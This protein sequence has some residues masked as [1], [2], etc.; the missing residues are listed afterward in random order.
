MAE[1]EL[2]N[3]NTTPA[4][5]EVKIE[6]SVASSPDGS[7]SDGSS[8][9]SSS[10]D[11]SSSDGSSSAGRSS[12]FKPL[13]KSSNSK[14]QENNNSVG[15]QKNRKRLEKNGQKRI[16]TA[17]IDTV[18][19]TSKKPR[20]NTVEDCNIKVE[21]I[22][23]DETDTNKE[24]E[25]NVIEIKKE[26]D[27]NES[28][29]TEMADGEQTNINQIGDVGENNQTN[30]SQTDVAEKNQKKVNQTGVA[31][32]NN[33]A[34]PSQTGDGGESD[35]TSDE[36]EYYLTVHNLPTEWTY[37]EIK[38]YLDQQVGHVD[39]MEMLKR[40]K[41][42]S[43]TIRLTF[44][45][46]DKCLQVFKKL[47]N[48]IVLDKRIRVKISDTYTANPTGIPSSIQDPALKQ[49]WISN[50]TIAA[51]RWR[52]DLDSFDIDPEGLYGLRPEFLK[53]LGIKPPINKMVHVTS[54]RCD[55]VELKEVM[56]LAGNVLMC[57]VV[58]S[59]PKY[60]KVVYSHPLEAVQAISMLNGQLYYGS[61]LKIAMDN[62]PPDSIVLPK[63]L[64]NIGQGLG[65]KARPIRNIVEQYHRYAN[66][67]T[68][69]ISPV[70]FSRIDFKHEYVNKIITEQKPEEIE[71][72]IKDFVKSRPACNILN[73]TVNLKAAT[74]ESE[75]A[76]T[77]A[78]DSK[79]EPAKNTPGGSNNN[80]GSNQKE[81][82]KQQSNSPR[83]VA[84]AFGALVPNPLARP[85]NLSGPSNPSGLSNL[86]GLG[87]QSGPGNQ[88]GLSK[89]SGP[90]YI[91]PNMMVNP[92]CNAMPMPG[93]RE[94]F[95]RPGNPQEP[96]RP[97]VPFNPPPMQR[98]P[99]AQPRPPFGPSAGMRPQGPPANFNGPSVPPVNYNGPQIPQGNFNRPRANL[100]NYV[101]VKFSNLP[102]STT[103]SLLCDLLAQCGQVV[104][105]QLP[106]PG[107]AVATFG[108]PSQAERCYQSFNGMNMEG[109][110]IEVGFA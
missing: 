100:G 13:R 28:D 2:S 57:C 60:A 29:P 69:S 75:G 7:S 27:G 10:S 72:R 71:E 51:T 43:C 65:I 18:D 89:Q 107:F 66:K 97:R 82:N 90:G 99:F 47:E 25:G 106:N 109:Y 54:F 36:E 1:N 88:G 4:D 105:V 83:M 94:P 81:V 73:P 84:P 22:D 38:N 20:I 42:K 101:T 96:F 41:S 31:G 9:D 68:S 50:E 45:S 98:P 17:P 63:G 77:K 103:F 53:A 21:N 35:A 6:P 12:K 33:Q 3:S 24:M 62:S 67:Q 93:P 58:S 79:T 74:D 8:S 30:V 70:V 95:F 23:E 64:V 32:A 15:S 11:G 19:G 76:A 5:I 14:C 61:P 49:F 91:H 55:K 104:S 48:K 56:E 86:S 108:H 80:T 87:N 44:Q 52:P 39:E 59:L 40:K 26:V 102:P 16:Q 37:V 46:I 34:N 78:S 92:M 110:I 85:G